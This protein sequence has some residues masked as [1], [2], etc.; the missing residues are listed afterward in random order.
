MGADSTVVLVKGG[1]VGSVVVVSKGGR[2]D[3]EVVAKG[4]IL[5]KRQ[6]QGPPSGRHR[7]RSPLLPQRV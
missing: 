4:Y 5:N 1:R 3:S 2:A 6:C 7:G